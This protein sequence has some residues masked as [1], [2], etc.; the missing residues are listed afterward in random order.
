[1]YDELLIKADAIDTKI[2]STSGLVSKAKCDSDK[3]GL[4]KM[5]KS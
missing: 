5:I 2:P 3:E 4:K 1:M